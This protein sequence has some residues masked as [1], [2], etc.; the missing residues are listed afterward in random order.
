MTGR[1]KLR[2]AQADTATREELLVALTARLHLPADAVRVTRYGRG[3]TTPIQ[4]DLVDGRSIRFEE[5]RFMYDGL[6]L[7]AQVVGSLGAAAPPDLPVFSR[8][9]AFEVYKTAVRACDLVAEDDHREQ[10]ED[11]IQRALRLAN[12]LDADYDDGQ[13]RYGALRWLEMQ[14]PFDPRFEH[15]VAN[16]PA[17]GLPAVRWTDGRV[18]LRTRDVSTLVRAGFGVAL[19]TGRIIGRLREVGC[20]SRRGDARKPGANRTDVENRARVSVIEVADDALTGCPQVSPNHRA[21]ARARVESWGHLGTES[22]SLT[23]QGIDGLGTPGGLGDTPEALGDTP[24]GATA[25]AADAAESRLVGRLL[26]EFDAVEITGG[27]A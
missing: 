24:S 22:E 20:E 3:D 7:A 9:D 15:E 13:D 5:A 6:K 18:W 10:A 19:D 23:P 4:I 8:S 21:R 11:W 27:E 1:D 17:R 14:P 26:T 25:D 2:A 12:P 16:D